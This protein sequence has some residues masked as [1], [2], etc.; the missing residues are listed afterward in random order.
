MQLQTVG[1]DG[2]T[3]EELTGRLYLRALHVV[4]M[5]VGAS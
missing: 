4:T 2:T 3:G 1:E 5:I